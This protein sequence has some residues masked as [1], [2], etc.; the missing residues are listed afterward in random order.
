MPFNL[1]KEKLLV[2]APH[3]DD[4]ILGCYGLMNKV[5]QNG[6]DVYVQILTMGNYTKINGT[7][8]SKETWK[9]EFLTATKFVGVKDYDIAFNTKKIKHLDEIQE[10]KLIELLES[11]SK[12]SISKICPTIVAIP[13]IFSSHQDHVYAYKAA[14]TALRP[15]PQNVAFMPKLVLSYE[16]P[17]YYFWSAYSE[18][19]KFSPNFYLELSKHDIE[20]KIMALNFYKSQILPNQRDGHK[21]ESLAKIRGSEIGIDYA[22]SFHMHRMFL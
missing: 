15:H 7:K 16:S 1:N 13:T 5:K 11:K 22:E 21:V 4:E 14:I 10:V 2:I 9:Q 17:E 20:N 18:F 12:I 19:G 8:V 3:A 6:G